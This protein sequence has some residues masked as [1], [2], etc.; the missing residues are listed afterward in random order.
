[1]PH[2]DSF[3]TEEEAHAHAEHIGLTRYQIV[4]QPGPL[5]E[6]MP[7]GGQEGIPTI[8]FYIELLD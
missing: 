3:A 7:L 1:M 5:A 4:A 6:M 2:T 8:R